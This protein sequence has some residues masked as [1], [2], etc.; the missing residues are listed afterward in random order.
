[1]SSEFVEGDSMTKYMA[2]SL[3]K[4][5]V[6]DLEVR[7]SSFN[8]NICHY[9]WIPSASYFLPQKDSYGKDLINN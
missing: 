3:R 7:L 6:P 8:S 9:Q 2:L 5:T 4:S 1:M